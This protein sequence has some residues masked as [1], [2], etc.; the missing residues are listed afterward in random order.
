MAVAGMA[1][2]GAAAFGLGDAKTQGA[3]GAVGNLLTGQG[4]GTNNTGTNA[5][6]NLVQTLGGLL[7]GK[8]AATNT[9]NATTNTA[10][11]SGNAPATNAVQNAVDSLF[12]PKPKKK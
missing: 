11:T 4:S 7:G 12:R 10:R 8:S 5:S 9:S 6:G 3:L 1:L 2:K